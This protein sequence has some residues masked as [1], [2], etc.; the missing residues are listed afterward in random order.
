ME[1]FEQEG[2]LHII[3]ADD[4]VGFNSAE[5]QVGMKEIVENKEYTEYTKYAGYTER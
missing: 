1:I 3:V 2:Q 5:L 4:G